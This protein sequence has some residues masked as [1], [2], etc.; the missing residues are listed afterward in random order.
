[1]VAVVTT[2]CFYYMVDTMKVSKV[3]KQYIDINS[4][5]PAPIRAPRPCK[6][7]ISVCL[8]MSCM[9]PLSAKWY[10][11]MV[12]RPGLKAPGG[13]PLHVQYHMTISVGLIDFNHPFMLLTHP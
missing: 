8:L 13:V 12:L 1:M 6:R 4:P 3:S 10:K 11:R 2:S 9:S 5:L 7:E